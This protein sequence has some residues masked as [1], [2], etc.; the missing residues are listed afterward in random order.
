MMMTMVM[1]MM[2]MMAVEREHTYRLELWVGALIADMRKYDN[3]LSDKDEAYEALRQKGRREEEAHKYQV[4][5]SVDV[6]GG[7]GGRVVGSKVG[8]GPAEALERRGKREEETHRYQ[9]R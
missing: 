4:R 6:G 7:G 1:M 8:G 3:M 5:M 9:V 2:M